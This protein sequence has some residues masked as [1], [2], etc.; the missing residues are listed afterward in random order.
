MVIKQFLRNFLVLPVMSLFAYKRLLCSHNFTSKMNLQFYYIVLVTCS[1]IYV[2][3]SS[4]EKVLPVEM[5]KA[6]DCASVDTGIRK[7]EVEA[8]IQDKINPYL[9]SVYGPVCG[10][11]EPSWTKLVDLNMSNTSQT[12]PTSSWRLVNTSSVRACGRTAACCQSATFSTQGK[13]Y[14]RVCGQVNGIQFGHPD[15]FYRSS[16][17]LETKYVDGV[18]IT[19]GSPQQHIWTFVG[20]VGAHNNQYFHSWCPCSNINRQG[21]THIP[22]FVGNSYFCDTGNFAT[23][24]RDIYYSGNPLWDGEGCSSISTCCQ[25]NNPPWFCA[26]LP[27]STRDDLEVRICGDEPPTSEDTVITRLEIYVK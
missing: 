15:G 4:P 22:A 27:D 14:T 11:G 23:T 8:L 12:C 24:H 3:L 5:D 25:F 17:R 2:S 18:S 19:H 9:N 6:A 7:N 26:S 1:N 21:T 10:C 20:Y 16:Q 13:S